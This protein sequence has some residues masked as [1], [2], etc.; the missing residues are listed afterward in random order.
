MRIMV[1][2]PPDKE[3]QPE[4]K[5]VVET[6]AEDVQASL[7][8]AFRRFNCGSGDPNSEDTRLRVRPM[9]MGDVVRAPLTPDGD[10]YVVMALGWKKITSKELNE[11]RKLSFA[12]R[13]MKC[14]GKGD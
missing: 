9:S 5:F 12:E 7:D 8:E 14:L 2:Y 6:K 10:Y 3:G 13:N 11:L 1:I 4:K